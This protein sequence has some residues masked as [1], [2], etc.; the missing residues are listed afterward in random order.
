MKTNKPMERRYIL[1]IDLDEHL[2][3]KWKKEWIKTRKAI[4]KCMNF[5]VVDITIKDSP[6]GR[7]HHIWIEFRA[8]RN[9]SDAELNKMQWLCGDDA[10]RVQINI[11]R[12][13][14]GVTFWNKLFSEVIWKRKSQNNYCKHCKILTLVRVIC[15]EN[16]GRKK[17][18][19]K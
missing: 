19:K 2:I 11:W 13:K 18:G 8:T 14:R 15:E 17:H 16:E 4:L 9:V 3:K 12:I 10:T 5:R 6:S 7:G 1:K